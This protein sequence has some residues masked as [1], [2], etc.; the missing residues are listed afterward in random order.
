MNMKVVTSVRDHATIARALSLSFMSM[1]TIAN[2]V[3]VSHVTVSRAINN[4]EKVHPDTLR[5]IRN[6]CNELKF[7][8][9]TIT[10]R[11][12]TVTL[13]ISGENNISPGDSILISSLVS[14]LNRHAVRVVI[15][16]FEG[17][18]ELPYIFQKAFI[19]TVRK[20]DQQS[21]TLAQKYASEVPFVAIND[22]DEV[23]GSKAV[24]VGSDHNGGIRKGMEHFLERGHKR[25]GYIA[26]GIHSRGL[27]QRFAGYRTIMEENKLF[28]PA[29]VLVGGEQMLPQGLQRL[30]KHGVTGVF[31]TESTLTFPVLYYLNCFG[32]EVPYDISVISSEYA[33]GMGF[34]YPPITCQVQPILRL[35]EL[36]TDIVLKKLGDSKSEISHQYFVPYELTVRESVKTLC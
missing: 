10:N 22:M 7:K 31:I 20:Y 11:L 19:A 29:L 35:A 14:Q 32:K 24:L 28:D 9:R 15:T 13:V 4:P 27:Q 34:L 2:R 3:G 1:Q 17:I 26:T 12:K 33:S 16:T 6:A 21:L 25:I 5:K 23:V 30:L 18:D 8:P 36:A